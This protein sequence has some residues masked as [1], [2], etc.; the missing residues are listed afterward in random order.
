MLICQGG[1]INTDSWAWKF[2]CSNVVAL[3]PAIWG[4]AIGMAVGGPVGAIVGDAIGYLGG[5]ALSSA[6]C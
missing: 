3:P 5:N 6:I 1:S 2:F 4:A